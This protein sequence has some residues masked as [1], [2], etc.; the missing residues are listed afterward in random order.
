MSVEYPNTELRCHL[1]KYADGPVPWNSAWNTLSNEV[2]STKLRFKQVSFQSCCFLP[3]NC[4][5]I[6]CLLN[7]RIGCC[8]ASFAS[9]QMVLCLKI[10]LEIDYETRYY[11]WSC[12]VSNLVFNRIVSSQLIASCQSTG[13]KKRKV[14]KMSMLGKTPVSMLLWMADEVLYTALILVSLQLERSGYGKVANIGEKDVIL[15]ISCWI[16]VEYEYLPNLTNVW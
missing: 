13:G 12:D 15:Q 4:H 10:V 5:A 1:W 14:G 8:D 3:V 7:I 2:I 16:S 9:M 6:E 11:A